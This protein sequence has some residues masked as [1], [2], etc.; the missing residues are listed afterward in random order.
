MYILKSESICLFPLILRRLN[1]QHLAWSI[2]VH[3]W[4]C[5]SSEIKYIVDSGS[6]S[7]PIRGNVSCSSGCV[8]TKT[9]VACP[10]VGVLFSREFFRVLGEH[11][12]QI[13]SVAFSPTAGDF[14]ETRSI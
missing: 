13:T 1:H 3:Y 14:P 9:S 2:I 6:V 5:F 7:K 8:N 10:V 12:P 4:A 11:Q